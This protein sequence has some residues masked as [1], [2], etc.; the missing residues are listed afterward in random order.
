MSIPYKITRHGSFFLN[1]YNTYF[2]KTLWI[3]IEKNHYGCHAFNVH[4]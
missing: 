4:K 1:T 2:V 3:T